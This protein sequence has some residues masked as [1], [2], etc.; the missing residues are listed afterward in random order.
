MRELFRR[1]VFNILIDNTDDHEKN[2]ALL[3]TDTQRYELSPAFDVLP[4]GQALGFQQMRVGE[5]EADST[6]AN[7]LSMSRMFSLDG[8][9]A[10]DEARKVAAVVDRWK[11]H[12]RSIGV[13]RG[14]IDL[15]AEQ[16]DRPFLR[17]QRRDLAG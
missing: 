10:I 2:H 15:Y 4:C 1:M 8:D 11:E 14:D 9:E 12:F 17:D 7:A 5:D 16:I 6:L 3:V 13:R